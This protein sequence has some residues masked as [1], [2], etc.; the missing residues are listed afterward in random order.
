MWLAD[1]LTADAA[2]FLSHQGWLSAGEVARY[3]RFIREERKR[4]FMVGRILLRYAL[5]S[6]LDISPQSIHVIEQRNSPPRL[7]GVESVPGFSI[8]HSG[9][10]VACAIGNQSSLGLDIE[11]LNGKRDL[12]A[13]GQQIFDE[14]AVKKIA[15]LQGM[16][17][18]RKFYEEW[19]KK[20]AR[21]KLGAN[22]PSEST[23][24]YYIFPHAEISIVLCSAQP[25]QK[26][27]VRNIFLP[28][29]RT[30]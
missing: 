25:I 15:Y 20:E 2:W 5:S 19:S 24:H 9:Q 30:S 8:S 6:F 7:D 10:W 22:I 29:I 1:S 11:V 16:E 12:V 26:T 21:Y 4:Q 18:T 23:P 17:R 14:D 13:L 27:I 3:E 28:N